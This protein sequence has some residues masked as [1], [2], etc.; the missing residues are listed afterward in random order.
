V[1]GRWDGI[2]VLL[3]GFPGE[4]GG[5]FRLGSERDIGGV[6]RNDMLGA[7]GALTGPGLLAAVVSLIQ[8]LSLDRDRD[9]GR[10]K[11]LLM[12][13]LGRPDLEILPARESRERKRVAESVIIFPEGAWLNRHCA[14]SGS[15]GPGQLTHMCFV[16]ASFLSCGPWPPLGGAALLLDSSATVAGLSNEDT[17][18]ECAHVSCEVIAVC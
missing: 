15:C 10:A 18:L 6:E 3:G 14:A 4:H 9:E 17:F 7:V 16:R 5:V 13:L 1:G 12:R 11:A 2:G 8:G